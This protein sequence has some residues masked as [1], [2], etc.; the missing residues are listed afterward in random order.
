MLNALCNIYA[1]FHLDSF[2][3]YVAPT[4][5]KMQILI[6]IFSAFICQRQACISYFSVTHAPLGLEWR[7]RTLKI[8]ADHR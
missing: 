3:Q 8:N 6:F 2:S 5:V 7:T 1:F 4:V